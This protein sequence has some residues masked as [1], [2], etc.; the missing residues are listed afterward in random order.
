MGECIGFENTE[1][2][3]HS[4]LLL[5]ALY[6]AV[7]RAQADSLRFIAELNLFVV[8]VVSF[9]RTGLFYCAGILL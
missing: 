9:V 3:T 5:I 7:V 2:K 6:G 4:M 1:L 8:V